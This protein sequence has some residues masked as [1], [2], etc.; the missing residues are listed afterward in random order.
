MTAT[1]ERPVIDL[2]R[3][4]LVTADVVATKLAIRRSTVYELSR[5]GHGAMPSVK[6]GRSRR[7]HLPSVEAWLE[8][9]RN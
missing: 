3:D 1:A 9:Q 4:S 5:R 2:S 6:I 7:W 8:E